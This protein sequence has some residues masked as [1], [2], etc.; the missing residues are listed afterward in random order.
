MSAAPASALSP[1]DFTNA[2]AREMLDAAPSTYRF[3]DR[4]YSDD[5]AR[6]IA[7][8]ALDAVTRA[9]DVDGP[10]SYGA[11]TPSAVAVAASGRLMAAVHFAWSMELRG[12]LMDLSVAAGIAGAEER[13][14]EDSAE[15]DAGY[16]CG[17]GARAV[18]L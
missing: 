3:A 14:R 13:R 9:Y 2:A 1:A 11:E 17:R 12:L 7:A 4:T 6:L 15:W 16:A 10:V 5:I 8:D 18:S